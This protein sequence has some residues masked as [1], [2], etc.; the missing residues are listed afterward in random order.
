MLLTHSKPIFFYTHWNY[1]KNRFFDV[2]RE[3]RNGKLAWNGLIHSLGQA[4]CVTLELGFAHPAKLWHWSVKT[5]SLSEAAMKLIILA[6]V[7]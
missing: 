2:L 6:E 5:K 7:Y 4:W 1:Q 3:N